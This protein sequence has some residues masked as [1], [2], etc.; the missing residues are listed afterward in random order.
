MSDVTRKR[1]LACVDDSPVADIVR[2]TAVNVARAMDVDL[3]VISV[4]SG[5]IEATLIDE[6]AQDDVVLGV[7]GSRRQ[8]T[9]PDLLGHVAQ[10]VVTTSRRPL[11][12]VPPDASPL[13][14]AGQ[15]FLVPLDGRTHT[16][17]A[18]APVLADLIEPMGT[19]IP[20]HVFHD[21]HVPMF[22]SSSQDRDVLADDFAARHLGRAVRGTERPRLRLG[23]PVEEILAAIR[24]DRVD[25]VVVCWGQHLHEG[26]AAVIRGL[27]AEGGVPV[28][29][30]PIHVDRNDDSGS[31]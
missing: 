5:S 13:T 3:D 12:V 10:A 29:L 4:D 16:S 28:V 25:A 14:G 20:L 9:T 7:L 19:I 26:R 24:R 15:R 18:I 30:Q 11:I 21:D 31:P 27:L 1:V 23:K 8:T 22:I 17:R 6:L 2:A